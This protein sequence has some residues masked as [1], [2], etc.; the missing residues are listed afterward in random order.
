M[1]NVGDCEIWVFLLLGVGV[2]CVIFV[3]VCFGIYYEGVFIFYLVYFFF[4]VRSRGKVCVIKVV[5][6]GFIVG[7]IFF[8]F[9]FGC[10][11]KKR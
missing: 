4:V 8:Y 6:E 11:G 10:Y 3:R 1:V 2:D 9:I 7:E 5:G